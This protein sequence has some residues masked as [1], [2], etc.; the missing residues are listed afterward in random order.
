MAGDIQ[1][2]AA[3]PDSSAK[4]D[5]H[6]LVDDATIRSDVVT[7]V[8]IKNGVITS[9]KLVDFDSQTAGDITFTDGSNWT[10]LNIGTKGQSL[11]VNTAASAPEWALLGKHYRKGLLVKSGTTAATD[12]K[13]TPGVVEIAGTMLISVADINIDIS[14]AGN[15]ADGNSE[16]AD[17]PVFVY[18]FDNSG[19]LGI[20]LATEPPDLSYSDDTTAEFPLRYQL[21]S[22]V[23]YRLLGIVHN[24]G[25]IQ[26]DMFA[27][28]DAVQYATGSFTAD[29]N[30]ETVFLGW[31]PDVVKWYLCSDSTPANDENIDNIG[32]VQRYGFIT[33]NPQPQALY[34]EQVD[35][36]ASSSVHSTSADGTALSL[37][38]MNL[39][40]TSQS[41][42]FT[43]DAPTNGIVLMWQAWAN[44]MHG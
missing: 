33:A 7:N 35:T 25:D 10:P 4:A 37:F 31:S 17:G 22:T 20:K 32:L 15:Y 3:L 19:S 36:G 44:G 13:V 1:K 5:F 39:Q 24:R 11:V 38:N 34:Y 14:S 6:N 21:Y 29:G 12:V 43:I 16:P 27:H 30:D 2:A 41:G 23:Y 9:A 40:T 28:F 26:L 42:S 8:M 18:G